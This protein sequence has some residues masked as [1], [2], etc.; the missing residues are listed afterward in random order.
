[1]AKITLDLRDAEKV[2]RC[3]LVGDVDDTDAVG[4]FKT[5][6]E[7]NPQIRQWPSLLDIREYE[8]GSLGAASLR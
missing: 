6:L 2:L 3:R 4:W 1:M 7:D 8:G 5:V